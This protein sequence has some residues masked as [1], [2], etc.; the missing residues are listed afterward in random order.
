[1]RP[2]ELKEDLR[3]GGKKIFKLAK[4]YRNPKT[5]ISNIKN[6]TG[7]VMTGKEEVNRTWTRYFERLL[8]VEIGGWG[9]GVEG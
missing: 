3:N 9:G 1:M 2:E 5:K 6:E 4:S 7:E 8:N